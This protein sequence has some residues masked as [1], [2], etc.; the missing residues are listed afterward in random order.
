MVAG[1]LELVLVAVPLLENIARY[2]LAC[3]EL[4]CCKA[5]CSIWKEG[6]VA[7]LF[8]SFHDP[9]MLDAAWEVGISRRYV[10]PGHCPSSSPCLCCM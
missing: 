3:I 8:C 4:F 1:F 6:G 7:Q 2:R 10:L 9:L 5:A